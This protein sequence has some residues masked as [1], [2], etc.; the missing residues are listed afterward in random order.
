MDLKPL[1]SADE[2][3][4]SKAY[5]RSAFNVYSL[6]AMSADNLPSEI[7]YKS[8]QNILPQQQSEAKIRKDP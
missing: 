1:K 7:A 5:S 2:W 8:P 4:R 3:K 6:H